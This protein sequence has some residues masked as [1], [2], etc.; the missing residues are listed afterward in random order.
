MKEPV[1]LTRAALEAFHADQIREHGG[2]LG[3]SDEA[4]LESALARPQRAWEYDVDADLASL[5]A[6]YGF[7]L[8]K[9][10]P[11]TDGNKRVAFVATNVFLLLNGYEV[12]APE[13]EVVSAMVRL[14]DGRLTRPKFADW[15]RKYM[16]RCEP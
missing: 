10:H 13:P 16:V 8:A 2:R 4:L 12:E 7:G 14:A 3:I 6:E 15:I 11:F 1:W 9:N 5:A